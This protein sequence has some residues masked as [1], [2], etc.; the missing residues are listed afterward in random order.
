MDKV[1]DVRGK[2]RLHPKKFADPLMTVEG[3]ERASVTLRKL[4][5]LWFNTGSLCNIACANCYIESSPT[6][7][8]LVYLSAKDVRS[9]LLE[10]E[11]F[12][13]RPREIGFTGG[14]PFMNPDF[15]QMMEDCLAYGYDVLILTN[16]MQPMLRPRVKEQLLNLQNR[17]G[18][19]IVMRVSL[20]HYSQALHETE[21]G[22]NTWGKAM[23]GLRW[24]SENGFTLNVA[25]RMLS[26]EPED[27]ER[28]GYANLFAQQGLTIDASDP[29]AL[30]LFPEMDET[31]DVP[32]ITTDCWNI[33]NVSPDSVMCANSRMV[34]KRKGETHPKVL[35]CTLLP[36][37]TQ[38]ELGKT[39]ADSAKTV[40]LNHPHCAKFCVLGG[41]SCSVSS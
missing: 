9:Y 3:T 34:V 25:G 31:Q 36:Y 17:Y 30:V 15:P 13:E 29:A 14:E 33:L 5:T 19:Q 24:L 4:D 11:G 23:E 27:A 41:A 20:D 8:R 21:R 7:D 37:D 26:G 16:A 40:H 2:T 39:L 38:F 28:S 6:N 22:A 1:V 10:L 18:A 12:S 32:E 35:P